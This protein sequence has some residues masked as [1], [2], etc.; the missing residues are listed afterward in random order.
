MIKPFASA[1]AALV[2]C[3]SQPDKLESRYILPVQYRSYSCDEISEE[4]TR[5]SGRVNELPSSLKSKADTDTAQAMVGAVLFWPAL[6][7]LEGAAVPTRKNAPCSRVNTARWN[8]KASRRSA[9]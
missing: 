6:F 5:I 3:A 7:F 1:A 2:G 8:K 9:I 4:M